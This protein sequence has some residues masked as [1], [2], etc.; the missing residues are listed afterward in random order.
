MEIK[1]TNSEKVWEILYLNTYGSRWIVVEKGTMNKI[2]VRTTYGDEVIERT[3][4]FFQSFG[5]YVS[6]T[7]SI[8]GKKVS[9]L[10]YDC[11]W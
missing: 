5:N 2:K 10:N 7:I 3:A 6:V 1:N 8:E 4:L 9:T 11:I